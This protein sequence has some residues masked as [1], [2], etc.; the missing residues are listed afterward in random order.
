MMRG[1]I[2]DALISVLRDT[3]EREW[4]SD[5]GVVEV[6]FFVRINYT[7]SPLE[8]LLNPC[9]NPTKPRRILSKEIF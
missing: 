9:V 4:R 1:L 5:I 3:K 8:D 2:A 7:A 6:Y